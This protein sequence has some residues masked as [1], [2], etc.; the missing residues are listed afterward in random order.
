MIL[1]N[2]HTHTHR[3]RTDQ[4]RSVPEHL[5]GNVVMVLYQ[6]AVLFVCV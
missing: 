4:R 1:L 3:E 2:T 5:Y 6:I